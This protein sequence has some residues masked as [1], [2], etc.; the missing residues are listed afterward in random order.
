VRL[1]LR[2]GV[3][4]GSETV[5]RT[6]DFAHTASKSKFRP[7]MDEHPKAAPIYNLHNYHY[8]H[9]Y[10]CDSEMGNMKLGQEAA[11]CAQRNF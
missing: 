10:Q 9:C 2:P 11:N 5:Q 4:E 8:Y 7:R 1:E 6:L 3:A